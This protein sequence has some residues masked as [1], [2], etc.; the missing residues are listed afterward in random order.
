MVESRE[1]PNQYRREEI[2]G[3]F[4][5]GILAILI[6][7]RS[8]GQKL[9]FY[10]SKVEYDLTWIVDMTILFWVLYGIF[11]VFAFSEDILGEGFSSFFDTIG[12]VILH[13]SLV[14]LIVVSLIFSVSIYPHRAN[15][16]AILFFVLFG[17]ASIIFVVNQIF[18]IKIS[19]ISNK[20][21]NISIENISPIS[22]IICIFIFIFFLYLPLQFES[23]IKYL[24]VLGLISTIIFLAVNV[25][26]LIEQRRKIAS[27][28][29]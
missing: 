8:Q 6:A 4:L 24:F 23:Y 21:K 18:T 1:K 10:Y 27:A 28:R 9:I 2:R 5:I 26:I 11:M 13:F 29:G 20:V 22:F 12:K 15:M 7:Y 25:F 17:G 14:F 16:F 19:N 3:L